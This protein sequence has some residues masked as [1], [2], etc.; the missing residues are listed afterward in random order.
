MN[1]GD[2]EER[3]R[4]ELPDRRKQTYASLEKRIDTH[5]AYLEAKLSKWIRRGLIAFSVIALACTLALIG[6]GAA[7][8]SVQGQRHEACENQNGRHD[9]TLGLFR[10]AAA[11]LV[12]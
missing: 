3:R 12:K 4:L 7:L 5:V 11:E 9:R 1:V 8:H 2:T 10:Q 6:Y